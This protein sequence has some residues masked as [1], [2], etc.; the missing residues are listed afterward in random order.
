MESAA[1]LAHPDDRDETR[2]QAVTQRD[3]AADGRFVYAVRTTGVYCKPSCSAR[4]ARRENVRFFAA[5]DAARAA[6]FRACKRC[7]PDAGAAD[8]HVAAIRAACEQLAQAEGALPLAQLAQDSGLSPHHFHRVFKRVTGVTPAEYRRTLRLQRAQRALHAA[9]RI[10]DAIY[11]AGFNA[12]SR[13]YAQAEAQLGMAPRVWRAGGRGETIR[14]AV[15]PCSLGQVLVAA[16]ERGICSILFADSAAQAEVELRARFAQAVLLP[17]EAD[18][19]QRLAQVVA[20]VDRPQGALDLPL[21][22][23]G[24]AFQHQVW[25]ALRE[26]P[27]G[28]TATYTQVAQRIGAPRAV[29]A[30]AKACADNPVAVAVPCHRVIRGDGALAGYRWGLARKQAL[31]AREKEGK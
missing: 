22:V 26:I 28:T 3:A 23:R 31:L 14:Y 9:P 27:V 17:A 7:R 18:F 5:A 29:R 13:F 1:A 6:G 20:Y 19:E 12:P 10:T 11:D 21:D 16:T 24:T 4:A 30:V 8:P 2:W 15:R 25:Q